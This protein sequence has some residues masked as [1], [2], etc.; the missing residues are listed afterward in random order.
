M[1]NNIKKRLETIVKECFWDYDISPEDIIKIA[2][3]NNIYMKKFLF[4]KILEN[5]TNLIRDLKI[6]LNKNDI[7]R[8]LK[9]YKTTNLRYNLTNKR[10]KIAEYFFLNKKSYIEE[11]EWQR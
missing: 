9:I 11:L 1:N 2:K 6:V 3:S 5:S 4:E 7:E 8:L 10:K